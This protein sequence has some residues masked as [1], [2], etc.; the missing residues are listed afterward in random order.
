MSAELD[1]LGGAFGRSVQ[2]DE[3]ERAAA[4][5]RSVGIEVAEVA[6]AV[7]LTAREPAL[8]LA[9]V[10]APVEYAAAELAI[11]G[12]AG[13]RGAAGIATEISATGAATRAA[14]STYRAGEAAVEGLF[15]DLAT[16]TG[17]AIG[18]TVAPTLL[19]AAVALGPAAAAVLEVPGAKEA[20]VT[21]GLGAGRE[22]DGILRDHPWLVPAAADGLD[23]LVLGAGIGVPGLGTW[24][25]W[26][27]GRLGVPYPPRDREEALGVI[28]AAT[29]GIALDESD[30]DVSVRLHDEGSA[31]AP[32]SVADL[33]APGGSTS[34]GSR[35]RV[36]GLPRPDGTW[37]WVVDVPGTRT[38]DPRAG[39]D[40]WDLTSNVLLS[41]EQQT[42]TT[43]AVARA[44]ADAQRRSGATGRSR[45]MLTGHSQGG[46]TAAALAADASF[47][48]RH[49][50]T[51]VVT[52]GAPV[53]NLAVPEDVS[54][55]SLEHTEDLVPGLEGAD[56][57]D[58]ETWVTVRRDV[59]GVLDPEDGA[60]RAH[61]VS[62]YAETARLVDASEDPSLVAW[63]RG[64]RDFLGDGG[65]DGAGS[66]A[67][68]LDYDVERVAR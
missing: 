45:V 66:E 19:G 5:L 20:A 41:A 48:K 10:V 24:L 35:V 27:S 46:L 37:T 62:H 11:L 18:A 54:V 9:G 64:A 38:F 36:T 60:S 4:T 51:H 50:V 59:A 6:V 16:A 63:R 1:V 42:L 49:E 31:P 44:L 30:H 29:K 8:A 22:L 7:G 26:R 28:I 39:D 56:N 12:C 68:V 3:L 55:L 40:P 34:G 17:V 13:P 25:G 23:G 67:V 58:R 32:T 65:L 57:P 33:V 21:L 2:L 15:D 47:R 14:V 53:A 43:Q 61:R 52:S